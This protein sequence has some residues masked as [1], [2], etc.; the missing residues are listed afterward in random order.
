VEYNPFDRVQQENP[1][2]V[3]EWLLREA[4]LYHNQA[5]DLWALSRHADV[6]AA[7]RTPGL[8]S[9]A[10]GVLLEQ[11][12][13]GPDAAEQIGFLAMDPPGHTR[14]RALVSG[15]FTPRR[16]AGLEPA[17]RAITRRRLAPALQAGTF[18]AV[19]VIG[20]IP[21]DVISELMGVPES[22]RAQLRSLSEIILARQDG[23]T[24]VTPAFKAAAQA[25][26]G[27]Y[28]D[29]I[30]DRRLNP[31]D[32]LTS[33]LVTAEIDGDRLSDQ[34][35][36]VVLRLIGVAG[37]ETVTKLATNAWYHAWLHPDQRAIAWQGGEG[38][39]RAWVEETLRYDGSAQMVA[40]RLTADTVMHDTL[41]PAGARVALVGGA[42]NRDPRVFPEPHRYDLTRDTGQTLAF[43]AGPHF[44]LGAALARLQLSVVAEEL[45]ASVAHYEIDTSGI[46]YIRSPN[47]RGFSALPTTV[48]LR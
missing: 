22:D 33:S 44:C 25:L 13:W 1:W 37:S 17:I 18:D 36:A 4:P 26:A 8:F 30:A 28:Q 7:F 20:M 40:R 24:A 14:M 39:V 19:S 29:L 23:Q 32:D 9:S 35:V 47:Q 27:Y 43:G 12:M 34:E 3:Y 16:V 6:N 45:I 10:H 2:P 11:D 48:K 46:R 41:V 5:L 42:A 38:P 15:G 21:V 31:R